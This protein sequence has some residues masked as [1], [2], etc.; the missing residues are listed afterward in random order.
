[1]LHNTDNI[2]KTFFPHILACDV[3]C[4]RIRGIKPCINKAIDYTLLVGLLLLQ[5]MRCHPIS[6][7]DVVSFGDIQ[8][9][10]QDIV[11]AKFNFTDIGA[12]SIHQCDYD[13]NESLLF[14]SDESTDMLVMAI[15]AVGFSYGILISVA[16]WIHASRH[17]NNVKIHPLTAALYSFTDR[18]FVID[19][20]IEIPISFY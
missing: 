4:Q 17:S 14:S 20:A 18:I 7:T 1:V 19:S 13:T 3:G 9:S 5:F 12:R 15:I 2:Q 16:V 10:T 8:E 11:S 6:I